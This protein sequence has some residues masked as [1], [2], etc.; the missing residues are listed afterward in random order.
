MFCLLFYSHYNECD[1]CS[2]IQEIE[3]AIV[4]LIFMDNLLAINHLSIVIS[5]ICLVD[6]PASLTVWLAQLIRA[7]AA[8]MR[9]RSRFDPSGVGK[10]RS[11]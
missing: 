4:I 3:V 6:L 2:S 5:I 11:N 10:M 9:V 7:L 8:P 1:I